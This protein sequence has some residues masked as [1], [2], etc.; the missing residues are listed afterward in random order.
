MK[1][2]HLFFSCVFLNSFCFFNSVYK[3][4]FPYWKMSY[5]GSFIEKNKINHISWQRWKLFFLLRIINFFFFC[6]AILTASSKT[7][8]RPYWVK[9]LHYMYLQPSYYSIN[10]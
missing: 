9:A 8:L 2:N 4:A 3:Q 6:M 10:F 1:Y 7:S 5:H